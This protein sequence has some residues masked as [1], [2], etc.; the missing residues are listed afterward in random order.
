[1]ADG[2]G[3]SR[4]LR[5]S[6]PRPPCPLTRGEPVLPRRTPPTELVF[7]AERLRHPVV[8]LPVTLAEAARASTV[9][10]LRDGTTML[11]ALVRM[12]GNWGRIGN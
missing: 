3:S 5:C 11:L 10:P 9:R 8:E 6:S 7:H 1:M 4:S 2:G 12:A